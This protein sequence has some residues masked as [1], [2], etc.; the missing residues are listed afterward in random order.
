M[1]EIKNAKKPKLN[2]ILSL[3]LGS[4]TGCLLAKR[5]LLTGFVFSGFGVGSTGM[6]DG[7]LSVI[8]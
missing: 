4:A 6:S 7:L 2:P 8:I 3:N 5:K 1:G